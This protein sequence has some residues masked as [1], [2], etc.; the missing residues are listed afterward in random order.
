MEVFIAEQGITAM[1]ISTNYIF[2]AAITEKTVQH[3]T[4]VFLAGDVTCRALQR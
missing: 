1:T 2:T 3:R 4:S